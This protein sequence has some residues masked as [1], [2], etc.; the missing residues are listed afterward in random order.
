MNTKDEKYWR[1]LNS[2]IQL[3]M[4]HGHLKWKLS[5]L[6]RMSKVSRALIYY[7]FGKSKKNIVLEACHYFGSILSGVDPELMAFYENGQVAQ[8]LYKNK[9]MLIKVPALIPFYFLFREHEDEI[10]N[11][12]RDYEA[13]GIKKRKLFYPHLN[14]VQIKALFA[15]Q[16]G[17]SLSNRIVNL[18]EIEIGLSMI[19]LS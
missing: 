18:R 12:I 1:I 5:D 10:G 11:I 13:K 3:E 15:L 7:Y 17:L 19:K 2:C 9:M 6:H 8:A 14:D 4:S 16:M